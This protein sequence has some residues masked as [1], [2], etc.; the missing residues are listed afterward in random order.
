MNSRLI[1]Q[2]EEVRCGATRVDVK[3]FFS[4]DTI[5]KPRALIWTCVYGYC[6]LV[7]F[8]SLVLL[9]TTYIYIYILHTTCY[10]SVAAAEVRELVVRLKDLRKCTSIVYQSPKESD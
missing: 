6:S 4:A 7:G 3:F 2:L 5:F 8:V 9:H 10:F 1:G